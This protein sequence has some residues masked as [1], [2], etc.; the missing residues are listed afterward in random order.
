METYFLMH[1]VKIVSDR[2]SHLTGHILKH[3]NNAEILKYDRPTCIH[4]YFE[5]RKSPTKSSVE[6]RV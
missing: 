2:S 6:S 3:S 1:F 5:G 4:K